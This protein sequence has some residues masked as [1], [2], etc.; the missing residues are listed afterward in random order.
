LISPN[1]ED[2]DLAGRPAETFM[3][4]QLLRVPNVAALASGTLFFLVAPEIKKCTI[5]HT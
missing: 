3:T 2:T 5:G 1:E 4:S